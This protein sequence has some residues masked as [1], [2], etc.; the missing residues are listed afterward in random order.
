MNKSPQIIYEIDNNLCVISR[1]TIVYISQKIE[2]LGSK[3]KNYEL[4]CIIF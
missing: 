1:K 3:K 4:S 2:S